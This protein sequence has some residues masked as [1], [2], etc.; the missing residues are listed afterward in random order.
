MRFSRRVVHRRHVYVNFGQEIRIFGWRGKWNGYSIVR[1]RD[2]SVPSI[3]GSVLRASALETNTNQGVQG[4]RS[5][6]GRL[7]RVS[8]ICRKVKLLYDPNKHVRNCSH[9]YRIVS[10]IVDSALIDEQQSCTDVRSVFMSILQ[11]SE[12]DNRD[13]KAAI[14]DY[15][16]AGIKT[17]I[18]LYLTSHVMYY[19]YL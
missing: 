12:L 7:I 15:I 5:E 16:A 1:L 2:Q 13:K 11:A 18:Y 4:F 17:V 8:A 10:E 3:T 19:N 9:L 14:I 6:R